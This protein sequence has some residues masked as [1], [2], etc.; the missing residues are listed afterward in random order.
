M[1]HGDFIMQKG[2]DGTMTNASI[3][4]LL[5]SGLADVLGALPTVKWMGES[6]HE[7]GLG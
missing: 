4:G 2:T 6:G 7:F 1:A 3:Q 5:V